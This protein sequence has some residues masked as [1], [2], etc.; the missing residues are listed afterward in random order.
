[1]EPL[2]I[3]IPGREVENNP[4]DSTE[5]L[6]IDKT[7]VI[8]AATRGEVVAS[9]PEE[10]DANKLIEFVYD[11]DTV[12]LADASTIEEVFPGT[13]A[14]L[15][16]LEN[17]DGVFDI[18]TEVYAGEQSRG[19]LLGK[20]TL[21]LVKIFT[22]KALSPLVSELAGKLEVRQLEGKSGLFRLIERSGGKEKFELLP[23]E[24]E[25]DGK[26]VLFLHGTASSTEGSFAELPGS[27]A[28]Q[29]ITQTYQKNVLA[30]QHETLTKSPLENVFDLVGQLPQK[31]TLTLISHSRGGLV[32]DVL[33]RF[34]LEEPRQRGFSANEKN[35]LRK[36]KRNE[37]LQWIEKIENAILSKNITIEKF[38]RVACTASGTTLASRRLDI[39]FNVLFN[40]IGLALA[41]AANPLYVAFKDLIA[42]L[43]ESKDDADVLPGLEVQ[44]PQSPFNQMLNNANP[45]ALL[46]SPLLVIAGDAKMSLRWRAMKVALSNLF[47]WDDNDF[48]VDTR[49]M[50]NGAKREKD[51]VQY[52]FDESAEVSHFNYFKNDPTRNALLLALKNSGITLIP[53]FS[54]LDTRAFSQDEIRNIN[55]SLPGG[56]VFRNVVSGKK[57]IVVLLPGIMG[58]TLTVRD[59]S[60]WI[61]F[62]SFVGGGLTSLQHS[63]DNNKNVRADAL[64]GSSYKKLTEYLA[65]DYDVVTFPFDW[66]TRMELNAA[67]LNRKL[68]EL[69]Q[70]NQPIKL[71]GHSMGGVLIR[72]FIVNHPDTWK[73]LNASKDFRLVFLGAPLGG[74]FRIPYVLFGLDSLIKTLDFIDIGN[75]QKD[76]LNVFSKFPGILSLL[77]LTTDSAN[78]FADPAT[79]KNMRDAFGESDWPLP[80][81]GLLSEFG[82]YRKK[83]NHEIDYGQAVYIAGQA[84]KN[85]QTISGYQ[86]TEKDTGS[87][88]RKVLEFLATKEGDESVTW[89]SGIPASMIA[90]NT[91][92]YSEVTHG[93]LANEQ[94]LFGAITDLLNTGLTNQLKRTRPTVRGLEKEF[95]AKEV[96]DFDLSPEGVE[97]SLLGLGS[98]QRFTAGDVPITISISNGDLKYAMYPLMVGHFQND[99]ILSAEKALDWHLDHELTRRHRLGLYPGA[100]GTSESLASVNARGFQGAVIVGLGRQGMLTEYRLT[101]TV[102]QGTAN[103]LANLNSKPNK[104]LLH[105]LKSK[106]IG[107]SCLIIGSGYGGLRIE[108]SVRA[109]IQGV[110]NAN[111]KVRHTYDA[112]L[113]IETIEFIEIYKDR[114]LA[115]VKAVNTIE[116]EESRSLNIFRTGNKIRKLIGWRERLPVEDTTEWW[117][118]INV[119]RYTEDEL[120]SEDQRRSLRFAISTDAA[121]VEER[122]L[123]TINDTLIGLLEDLSTKDEWSPEL[124]KAIFELMVPNDFKDQVKRQNNINWILDKYTAAFPWELLQ[125]S[126]ANAR[127]LSVNAGMIR[128]L[129]TGDFRI[130]VIPVVERTAI[131]IGDPN[132]KNPA[133]QLPA[134]YKEGKRVAELLNLQGFEVNTLLNESAAHILLNLFSKNYKIVHLAGHGVFSNDP[135]QPTGMVIG[136]NAFLTPAYIDQMSNVPELVFVNCCYLGQTDGTAEEYNRSRFRLAANIGTQLIEIGVKAVVVAGW[137]VNDSAALEFA[138]RFY[139]A[140]FEGDNFGE[141]IQKARRAIFEN[142]GPRNNTWGAYQCYGDPFYKL[143]ND[144][145]KTQETYEFIIPEEAEIELGNLLNKI[146][147]GGYDPVE[148]LQTI[149]AI[150]KALTRAGIKSG[151]ITELQALLYSALNKYELAV[152]KFEALWK[153]DKAT[154]SFSATEKYCNTKVKLHVQQVKQKGKNDPMVIKKAQ[155]ALREVIADLEGLIRFGATVERINILASTHKRLALISQGEDKKEAYK[156]SASY[157]RK[158]YE[159]AENTSK[160]YPLTNWLSIEQALVLADTRGWGKDPLPKKSEVQKALDVELEHIHQKEGEEKEYWDWI[161]EATLLLCK[162]ILGDSKASYELILEEYSTAWKM[163]G[164][165][166]QQQAEIEHLEFLEDA[167]AMNSSE[168]ESEIIGIVSRL[169]MALQGMG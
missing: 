153:E 161:A 148:T 24:F 160:Y 133:I 167:L 146:E 3:R 47:F 156:C 138:E 139:Q 54:K 26:Y 118:R 9:R 88:K 38:I 59:K 152:A 61:N 72:D 159:T 29:F 53:G 5:T 95:K 7:Y 19:G 150:D 45:E 168:K 86:L 84:R 147:R 81:E 92:Y 85:K 124:A 96:F 109:I 162:R 22:K 21:K 89:E 55:L 74:S 44:N 111:S 16:S 78:D 141:A 117:T 108:D 2:K 75:S 68:I 48:V 101:S 100:V 144:T 73:E 43:I 131:V 166:G 99:G 15:R 122:S 127:P 80:D 142:Y 143:S 71:I 23:P 36:L 165:Q 6:T 112:P 37:D 10:L 134:A 126:V 60:V 137:A 58:S 120:L 115:C 123:N 94:K 63:D 163:I 40:V 103:Y 155:D 52:F 57:P 113:T 158:A 39:Y 35:Y 98:E 25:P 129:A 28:W 77:P 64:V 42:A 90:Q 41:Q 76:L 154:F 65:L 149:D 32:G 121:R 14:Q 135:D 97:K 125:D 12:W 140:M 114:A 102:E 1:M 93:E 50:Y 157:Y 4:A 107:L 87:G 83:V 33:S 169:R 51:K 27:A 110:Q 130:N 116:K 18:P 119:R 67:A 151:R 34:C 20:I 164:T 70:Y 69:R 128:Q 79:W 145:R 13:S 104:P 30:F 66:R 11:D 31:A 91:V 136:P 49:S 56:K 62:L 105:D 8:G 106:R 46:N 132:L 17:R 82:D